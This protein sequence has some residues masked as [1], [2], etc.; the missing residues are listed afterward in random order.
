MPRAA[1]N[2]FGDFVVEDVILSVTAKFLDLYLGGTRFKS[3]PGYH[4]S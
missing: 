3:Q 1:F 4:H 2:D